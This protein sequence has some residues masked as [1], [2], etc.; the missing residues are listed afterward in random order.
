M[1]RSH[2]NKGRARNGPAFVQIHH[3]FR[4]TEA[5]R[6][7]GPYS[8]LLYIEMKAKYSGAN[9]GEIPMSY[10]EAAEL[11]GCSNRPVIIGFQE[12]QDRGFI[13]PV[14]KGAFSWKVRFEGTGRATT[15]RLT[16][17][18]QDWPERSLAPTYE[19]KTWSPPP[20]ENKTRRAKSTRMACKKH[21]ISEG[22]A[23]GKHPIG[24][25]KARH[26]AQSDGG[27]G[28]QKARTS[29][30]TIS[31]QPVG[32]ISS[33]LLNSPILKKAKDEVRRQS[34]KNG[35]AK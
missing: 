24:V 34:K 27:H 31:L 12:L 29:I 16:E 13:V 30:S 4:K 18:A 21:P 35:A 3:W 23:C 6:S 14:Q 10:R 8:K 11:L 26:S 32:Q 17:I 7:L 19:F 28:V 15:W 33:A 22:M 2:N 1:S 20:A 25:K 5:W 9:N